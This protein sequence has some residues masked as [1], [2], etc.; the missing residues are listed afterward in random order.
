MAFMLSSD[1]YKMGLS[2]GDVKHSNK[3]SFKLKVWGILV[4]DSTVPSLCWGGKMTSLAY[5]P[6]KIEAAGEWTVR[7]RE[8]EGS[9]T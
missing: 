8:M 1:T 5:R 3:T 2:W 6:D 7:Y 9:W 4:L